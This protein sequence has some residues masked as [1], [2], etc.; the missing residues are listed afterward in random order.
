MIEVPSWLLSHL[1]FCLVGS[2]KLTSGPHQFIKLFTVGL[3][4]K[5]ANY[6][7]K[8]TQILFLLSF[9][10]QILRFNVSFFIEGSKLFIRSSMSF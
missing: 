6:S 3:L 9:I 2:Q 4:T 10:S 8:E 7:S 1:R 5:G